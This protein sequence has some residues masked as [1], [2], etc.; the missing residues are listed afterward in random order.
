[1]FHYNLM[2]T[3]HKN[4]R[5]QS[6]MTFVYQGH[7]KVTKFGEINS[8][9]FEDYIYLRPA[10]K[11]TKEKMKKVSARDRTGDLLRVRQT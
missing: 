7:E 6:A 3:A 5:R 10:G 11:N 2:C 4:L 9:N 8:K 1:M